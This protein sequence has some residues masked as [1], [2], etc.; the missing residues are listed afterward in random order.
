MPAAHR[1][2]I[3]AERGPAI[4]LPDQRKGADMDEP[5]SAP[6]RAVCGCSFLFKLIGPLA[7]AGLAQTLF[8]FQRG[9]TTIGGFALL[10]LVV[11]ALVRPVLWRDRSARLALAAAAFFALALAADPG[12]LA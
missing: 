12:F 10:L 3:K 5:H 8:V 7:L 9:G 4:P 6:R 1:R 2:R 11:A